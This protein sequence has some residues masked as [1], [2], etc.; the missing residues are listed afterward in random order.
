MP[1]NFKTIKS[2]K[3]GWTK[4]PNAILR[5]KD[6][7][8]DAKIVIFFLLS[9]T[10]NYTISI[11]GISKT[12]NLSE[13]K[14]KRAVELLQK[15]GYLRIEKVRNGSLFG[16]YMWLI[17]DI[18]GTFRKFTGETSKNETSDNGISKNEIL[19]N[20]TSEYETTV[21]ATTYELPIGEEPTMKEYVFEGQMG[22]QLHHQE[23]AEEEDAETLPSNS[24]SFTSTESSSEANASPLPSKTPTGQPAVLDQ[25]EYQYQQF[26]KK[27]PKKPYGD[28][29]AA[30]R[31]AFFE[32]TAL[33]G[34]FA[35][36]MAG[37]D[38]WCNSVD[39]HKEGGRYIT[40]PLYFLTTHKWEEIPRTINTEID[41]ELLKFMNVPTEVI[42]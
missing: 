18:S 42:L 33:D 12:I 28:D 20:E 14:V 24:P 16:G 4:Q 15:T 7:T 9:I 22:E 29:M 26:L 5:D 1:D 34:S 36:I 32:A 37:L 25:R 39:W 38:A 8:S 23:R 41:P 13:S 40:K 21:S 2:T 30:T 35:E 17:S 6:L 27:Y 19:R 31:E 10:K 3:K 11:R